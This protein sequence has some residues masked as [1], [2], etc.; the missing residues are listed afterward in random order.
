MVL[1]FSWRGFPLGPRG[2]MASWSRNGYLRSLFCRQGRLST[3]GERS[4]CW[5]AGYQKHGRGQ[6]G[7]SAS[8]SG[9]HRCPRGTSHGALDRPGDCSPTGALA[10]PS[11]RCL[12][13][14]LKRA[15]G[16]ETTSLVSEPPPYNAPRAVVGAPDI[17]YNSSSSHLS[18]CEGAPIMNRTARAGGSQ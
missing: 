2:P 16:G 4:D 13:G 17:F 18:P 15:P 14:C 7:C 6:M 5:L 11:K 3:E 8:P 12:P 10:L 9:C 1:S